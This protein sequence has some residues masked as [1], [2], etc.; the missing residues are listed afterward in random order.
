[1]RVVML[2]AG[3]GGMYCGSCLHD[4]RLAAEL[5]AQ[6]RDVVL[7]PLYTPLRTDEEDVS[8]PRV[9]YGG[10]SVY[11]RHISPLFRTA[12]RWLE[13]LLDARWLLRLAGRRAGATRPE[14][15]GA[16]TV[17]LLQ[18]E[19]GPQRRELDK[20]V[21]LL[22]PLRPDLVQLPNLMFLGAARR[23]RETLAVPIVCELTGED[24]F[25]DRLRPPYRAQALDAIRAR[26]ANVDAFIA[27]TQYYRT[28]AA[29]HF[30]LPDERVHHVPLGIRAAEF[31]AADR[32]HVGQPRPF[33]IGHL[34]RV[35]PEKGLEELV[36]AFLLL[37]TAGR[38]CRL[39]V[40]GYLPDSERSF[41]K[42]LRDEIRGAGC[43]TAFDYVGSPS[44]AEK[45]H[46]LHTLDAFSAPAAYPESKGLYVLEALAAGVPV[47]QPDHGAFPE[48]LRAAGGG[49]LVPPGDSS[50]LAAALAR[51]M[52]E[53]ELRK[54]LGAAGQAAVRREHDSAHTARAAWALYERL[55][56]EHAPEL[57]NPD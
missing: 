27:F 30:G 29:T 25:L 32:P 41:L 49:L 19:H 26:A 28:H 8:V 7:T 5:R 10:V 36:R 56:T 23:L 43:A 46:F 40:A 55:V 31:A 52:D 13:A 45:I 17:E 15:A 34:A 21:D 47:V 4:N 39:H 24:I 44:R 16:L 3:A 54:R 33:T 51:L 42:G 35:C 48:L 22:R 57:R 37:R 20:L 2:A 18:G 11:L 12:P 50:A 14:D 53:P 1:M 6:G 38:D 9:A